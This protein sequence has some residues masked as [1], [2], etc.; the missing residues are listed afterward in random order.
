M[1]RR[2]FGL[3]LVV[4]CVTL[5]AGCKEGKGVGNAENPVTT[6]FECDVE[7][8]YTDMN[9]KGHLIRST[10]GTMSLAVSE[11]ESLS[12]FTMLW[13]GE[14]ISFKLNGFSFDV[15]PE[16]IPQGALGKSVLGALDDALSH[17]TQGE[18]TEAGLVTKGTT[19][20]G[21]YEIVSNPKTGALLSLKV[22]SA[23]LAAT[24]S[25][26]EITSTTT[27]AGS[28]TSTTKAS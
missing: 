9:L 16:V 12:G 24:F 1:L 5:I 8:Q 18:T 21:D 28:S 15:N 20:S 26:F 25:N 2:L 17:P 6:G 23:N 4:C 13:D 10:A 14:K 22:P 27:T 11:P 3:L 19:P 7:I